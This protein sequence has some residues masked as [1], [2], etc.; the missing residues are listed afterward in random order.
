MWKKALFIFSVI[1][2]SHNIAACSGPLEEIEPTFRPSREVIAS[3]SNAD[4]LIGDEWHLLSLNGGAPIAGVD[5]TLTFD[6]ELA[7]GS[8][9]CNQYGGHYRAGEDGNLEIPEIENTAADCVTPNGIMEQE[10]AYF[11]TLQEAV[12]FEIV[13]GRL[14]IDNADGDVILVFSRGAHSFSDSFDGTEWILVSLNGEALLRR[15]NITLE[16]D[17][18][19]ASGFAGCNGY[20]GNY[21]TG[22]GGAFSL[23]D[24]ANTEQGCLEPDGVMKQEQTY[25]AALRAAETYL[26]AEG[27]LEIRDTTGQQILIFELKEQ[28]AMDPAELIGT[29]WR[30]V[31]LDDFF[32]VEGSPIT[33]SFVDESAY[34]G[35][36]GCRTYEGVYQAIGDDISFSF[37]QMSE[38]ACPDLELYLVQ[39]AE[40]T[41]ALGLATDYR[42]VENRLEMDTADGRTLVFEPAAGAKD[43]DLHGTAWWLTT[44]IE[45]E[46]ARSLIAGTQIGIYFLNGELTGNAGCNEYF[47]S[48]QASDGVLAIDDI[49]FTEM[50]CIQPEGVMQ[51][52]GEYIGFLKDATRYRLEGDKLVFDT[53]DSRALQYTAKAMRIG[54]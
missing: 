17:Q 13:D 1:I 20:F 18:D 38:T 39:E 36:A 49:S 42:L 50:A 37:I 10:S 24:L 26:H 9:G 25:L 34:R 35:D 2:L 21:S 12:W 11:L 15:T 16:L 40:Y 46:T 3:P 47:G 45:G 51:Q 4:D 43:D 29:D 32:P 14:E 7:G 33:L 23:H 22:P 48:Y 31:G 30:L 19:L 41:D 54:E 6:G 8:A 44:F 28:L 27:R 52:E 5:L 53:R